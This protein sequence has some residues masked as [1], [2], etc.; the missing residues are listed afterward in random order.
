MDG[1][2]SLAKECLHILF[3]TFVHKCIN[4]SKYIHAN[5]VVVMIV[6]LVIIYRG[7]LSIFLLKVLFTTTS[8]DPVCSA[9]SCATSPLTFV[10]TLSFNF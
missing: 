7:S 10:L 4:K 5:V 8:T 9:S 6:V 2:I 3:S 1:Y